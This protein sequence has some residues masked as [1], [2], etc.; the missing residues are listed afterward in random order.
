MLV[1]Q[2][3]VDVFQ[4]NMSEMPTL[5]EYVE[6][7]IC[8]GESSEIVD[9]FEMAKEECGCGEDEMMMGEGSM[10]EDEE[11]EEEETTVSTANGTGSAGS[12]EDK[13]MESKE[14]KGTMS[15][16]RIEGR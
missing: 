10:E 5:K 1:F 13:S 4:D 3:L 15:W 14:G 11:E 8:Y 16:T 7:Q 12:G 9:L 2:I 6:E